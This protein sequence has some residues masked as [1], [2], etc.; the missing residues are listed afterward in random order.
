MLIPDI[1]GIFSNPYISLKD[2]AFHFVF[3]VQSSSD[4]RQI[5][6]PVLSKLPFKVAVAPQKPAHINNNA[7]LAYSCEYFECFSQTGESLHVLKNPTVVRVN[8]DYHISREEIK[9]VNESQTDDWEYAVY[10][11]GQF[12]SGDGIGVVSQE[13]STIV[14]PAHE[15]D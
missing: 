8:M 10:L 9:A 11:Q 1:D 6:K 7:I 13:V 15:I 4:L 12:D 5:A 14:A 2:Q 3:S